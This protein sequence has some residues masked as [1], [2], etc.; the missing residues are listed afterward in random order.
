MLYFY[1]RENIKDKS[2]YND[3]V[4]RELSDDDYFSVIVKGVERNSRRSYNFERKPCFFNTEKSDEEKRLCRCLVCYNEESKSAQCDECA[5]KDEEFYAKPVKNATFI[6]FEVPV[7]NKRNDQI[8]RIDLL[9]TDKNN[10]DLYCVEFKPYWN[11]E[12]LLRMVAEIITYTYVLDNDRTNF[13]KKYNPEKKYKPYK[14]AIMFMEN[15]EQWKQWTDKNY[16]HF[17][18]DRLREI[19]KKEDITVFC[20]KL[21]N[22]EYI[23][24]KLN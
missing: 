8:G 7:S 5:L 24:E 17:A 11:V 12:S 16:R 18:C 19:I 2:K 4:K 21:D 23:V 22:D 20:L 6:D 14:K 10:N 13:E 3:I 9:M 15:S 1:K